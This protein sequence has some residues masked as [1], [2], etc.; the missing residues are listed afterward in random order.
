MESSL[1]QRFAILTLFTLLF[2]L[3]DR[4]YADQPMFHAEQG[5]A[6]GGYDTVA[7]FVEGQAIKGHRK[8]AVM[9]KGAVWH[10]VTKDNQVSFEAD[11]RAYAPRFGGYCA[12][13]VSQGYLMSGSPES[14]Q[15]VGGELF[16]LY[17]PGVHQIWQYQSTELISHARDNWPSV[18]KQ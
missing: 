9:W 18:L 2:Q 10:F 11:P 7:F 1:L 4:A 6:I 16:L 12:F 15:I 3:P 14:W 8:F 13:A 5:V 17:G